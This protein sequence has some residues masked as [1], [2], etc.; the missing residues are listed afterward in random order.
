[1]LK[2]RKEGSEQ[3]IT[4]ISCLTD[5]TSEDFSSVT[6]KINLRGFFQLDE[7]IGCPDCADGGAEWIEIRTI[8]KTQKVTF[9]YMNEPSV[10]NNYIDELRAILSN[11]DSCVE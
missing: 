7:I 10:V 5:Y 9:G 11:I 8:E 6:S 1:M 4:P 2:Y 3:I